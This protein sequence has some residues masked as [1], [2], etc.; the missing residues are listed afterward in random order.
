MIIAEA[1]LKLVYDRLTFRFS[2]DILD[3]SG[4]LSRPVNRDFRVALAELDVVFFARF[5]LGHHL[6]SALGELHYEMAAELEYLMSTD[7]RADSLLILPRGF[8]KSTWYTLIAPLWCA[9]YEKAHY[10]VVASDSSEQSEELLGTVKTELEENER[11]LEDFGDMRGDTWSKELIELSNQ[12]RI[13]PLGAGKK[14]RGRKY[15]LWRPDLIIFDDIENLE[16]VVSP[17]QVKKRKKWYYQSAMYAGGPTTKTLTVGNLLS[18]DCLLAELKKTRPRVIERSGVVTWAE[19]QGLWDTWEEILVNITNPMCEEDALAFY[20]TNKIVMDL[21][22]KSAWP[23]RFSYYDL[24]VIRAKQGHTAFAIEIQN[25]PESAMKSFF[26]KIQYFDWELRGDDVWMIPQSGAPAVLLKECAIF[27]FTDPS[28]GKTHQS[29]YS[30]I[31]NI[32]KARNGIMFVIV[33]DIKRRAPNKIITAQNFYGEQYTF[34]SWG[35]E[36]VQF[37]AFFATRSAEVSAEAGT[38]I[39]FIAIPQTKN[40]DLRIQSLEPDLQNGYLLLC[41]T[42]QEL[43]KRQLNAFPVGHRDGPDALE[44]CR[45]LCRKHTFLS[46]AEVTV[47]ETHTFKRGRPLIDRSRHPIEDPYAKYEPAEVLGKI[48]IVDEDTGEKKEVELAVPIPHF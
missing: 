22:A 48:W 34:T 24:M 31:I 14:I 13:R 12:V 46:A 39:P 8:G 41:A 1:D 33:S 11:I 40:Q 28:L 27:G 35:L 25:D 6:Y 19:N 30:A 3:E 26:Q 29:D 42:G 16:E 43:L 45:T 23:E 47:A 7:G 36:S 32:A 10:I 9:L 17:T 44:G 5:Y 18:P 15:R 4:L 20:N 2:P 21:G 37:Q 38:Y